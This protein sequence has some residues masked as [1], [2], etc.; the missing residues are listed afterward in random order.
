MRI[1]RYQDINLL[2]TSE[3]TQQIITKIPHNHWR[4]IERFFVFCVSCFVF[5]APTHLVIEHQ[6]GGNLAEARWRWVLPVDDEGDDVLGQGGH[7]AAIGPRSQGGELGDRVTLVSAVLGGL[8]VL[9][10]HDQVGP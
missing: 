1:F 3:V 5:V 8:A 6:V 9:V 10:G 2:Q 4:L 7:D